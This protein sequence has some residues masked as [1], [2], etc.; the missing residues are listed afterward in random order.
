MPT[1][2][3][4]NVLLAPLRNR[5]HVVLAAPSRLAQALVLFHRE[6]P[7]SWRRFEIHADRGSGQTPVSPPAKPSSFPE[8][9][10]AEDFVPRPLLLL[11]RADERERRSP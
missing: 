5:H 4:E 11:I 8:L 2:H 1:Q 6:A 7:F 10:F 3:P 9:P